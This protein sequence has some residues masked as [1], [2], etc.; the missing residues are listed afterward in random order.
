[1]PTGCPPS[2]AREWAV[3]LVCSTFYSFP[4]WEI[5]SGNRKKAAPFSRLDA[6]GGLFTAADMDF[7]KLSWFHWKGRPP[8][9]IGTVDISS[10]WP[11]PP[12]RGHGRGL[13]P[14]LRR[15][16][17][18]LYLHGADLLQGLVLPGQKTFSCC[19]S[20]PGSTRRRCRS[21]ATTRSAWRRRPRSPSS[22]PVRTCWTSTWAAPWANRQ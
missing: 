3:S 4:V 14:D 13:P 11:W 12:W 5:P 8:L 21:S 9:N 17:G 2:A 20:S 19:S 1:M 10:H 15:T 6:H 18:G 22:A 7:D 16:G